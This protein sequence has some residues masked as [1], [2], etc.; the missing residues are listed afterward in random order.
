MKLN[1]KKEISYKKRKE[2]KTIKST[3]LIIKNGKKT[4]QSILHQE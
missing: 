3:F 1:E 2:L 4:D